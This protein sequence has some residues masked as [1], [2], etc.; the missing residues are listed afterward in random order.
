V[1]HF[2][3]QA[4]LWQNPFVL[5]RELRLLLPMSGDFTAVRNSALTLLAEH[6]HGCTGA[7]MVTHGFSIELLNQLI[8]DGFAT[9]RTERAIRGDKSIEIVRLKITDAGR[10]AL[11]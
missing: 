1:E 4:G 3:Q 7:M 11:G 6:A 10:R 5:K 9:A 2:S 8:R